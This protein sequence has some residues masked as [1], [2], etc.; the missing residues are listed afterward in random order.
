MIVSDAMA[1]NSKQ[2]LYA[3]IYNYLINSKRYGSAKQFLLEADVPI[4]EEYK[5]NINNSTHEVPKSNVPKD[6]FPTK[7]LMDC[8]DTFLLEWWKCF[9]ALRGFVEETPIESLKHPNAEPLVPI[10]Q[11]E[12]F[13]GMRQ[14][15]AIPADNGSKSLPQQQNV[16]M[17]PMMNPYAYY[18]NPQ[19]YGNFNYMPV[20]SDPQQ[21]QNMTGGLSADNMAF[22][23]QQAQQYNYHLQQQQQQLQHQ[24]FQQ[25]QQQQQQPS[26]FSKLK[27]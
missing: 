2:L 9:S 1:K 27:K 13:V 17:Y 15:P 12:Q 26:P 8:E 25:Q 5:N 19:N 21:Q 16:P 14:S 20:P 18:G 7:M 22:L 11:Q 3:H 6:L 24:Q 10:F 4:Y 23:Q